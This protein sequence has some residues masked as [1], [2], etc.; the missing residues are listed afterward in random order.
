MDHLL[1]K[2]R[3]LYKD[4]E[5]IALSA[6][7]VVSAV[8]FFLF[9]SSGIHVLPPPPQ[10][11]PEGW[12]AGME[13]VASFNTLGFLMSVAL[14]VLAYGIWTWAFLPSPAVIYTQG[15]LR[16]IFGRKVEIE[17]SIGRRFRVLLENGSYINMTCKM[18]EPESGEWFVYKLVSSKMTDNNL[19]EIA[20]RHGMAVSEG[21]FTSW[22]SNDELHHRILLLAKAMSLVPTS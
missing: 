16:G 7:L 20:L 15:V 4:R 14:M 11:F 19:E 10:L 18:K 8:A 1:K 2:A 12:A 3:A 22:V 9:Y 6:L 13:V 21:R 17:Q 5:R